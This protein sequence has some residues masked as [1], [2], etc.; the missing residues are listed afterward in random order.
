MK[1][2]RRPKRTNQQESA[3]K[4]L[5]VFLERNRH[6]IAIIAILVQV[7]STLVAIIGPS[8]H[9]N[10]QVIEIRV[11]MVESEECVMGQVPL[12]ALFIG[13]RPQKKS[14]ISVGTYGYSRTGRTHK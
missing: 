2:R 11:E 7:L 3:L 4:G 10:R 1:K 6:I 14:I 12:H 5:R 8:C 13:V 9:G